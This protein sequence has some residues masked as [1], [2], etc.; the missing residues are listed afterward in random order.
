MYEEDASFIQINGHVSG[1]IPIHRS[2]RQGC[3][4]SMLFFA[5]SV[6]PLLRILD[7]ELLGIRF[8]KRARMTV[9]VAYA[10][11]ITIFVTTPTETPVISDAIKCYEKATGARLNTRK[12]KALAVGG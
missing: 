11:H 10:N 2:V 12:S 1:P 3:L 8:G 5:S 9:V 7:Q 6:D 4:I